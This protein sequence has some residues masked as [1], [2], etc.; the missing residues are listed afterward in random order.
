MKEKIL[1]ASITSERDK[2]FQICTKIIDR[3]GK[4]F[5]RKEALNNESKKHIQSLIT[6]ENVLKET[7]KNCELFKIRKISAINDNW[8]EFSF[9]DGITLD[10]YLN[11]FNEEK[12]TELL[13]GLWNELLNCPLTN[14]KVNKSFRRVF[15][16]SLTDIDNLHWSKNQNVDLLLSNI[17]LQNDKYIIS[18]YEW[19][20]SFAVPLEFIYFRSVYY[21][22]AL[23]DK[24]RYYQL[25]R[26]RKSD[27]N[28][29][30]SAEKAFQ[31]F[32]AGNTVS[33]WDSFDRFSV[34]FEN[35][36]IKK[37]RSQEKQERDENLS[38]NNELRNKNEQIIQ[39]LSSERELIEIK[40]SA[41][42]K[43]MYGW[44]RLRDKILPKGSRRRIVVKVFADIIRHPVKTISKLSLQRIGKFIIFLIKG[45]VNKIAEKFDDITIS[46][47]E[48]MKLDVSTG[49]NYKKLYFNEIKDPLISVIVPVYNQF[50]Y[51]YHCLEAIL[52]HCKNVSYEVILADDNSNDQTEKINEY[53][54]NVR[55]IRNK[56]NLGFLRNCNSASKYASGKYIVFLN[57]DTQVQER[58][59]ESMLELIESDVT[60]GMVGSRLVY[61]DGSLQEAGGIIWADGSGWNYGRG[62]SPLDP[63]YNYV[64]DVDYISGAS[65]MIRKDLWKKIGGFD[66]RYA[67][68]YYEDSDLTFNVRKHGYRVVYQPQSVVVHFEGVTNGTDENSGH[69][70]YQ[71]VNKEKFVEKWKNELKDQYPSESFL[72]KARERGKNKKMD[73]FIDHY[74]P[75]YDKDAGSKSSISYMKLFLN[76]GYTVKLIPDNFYKDEPY[77][78]QFQQM[79]IEVLY[80]DWYANHI[81]DWLQENSKD[82]DYIFSNRPHITI[83]YIDF[84]KDR[85]DIKLVYYGHDLH[86]LRTGREYEVNKDP[87]IFKEMKDWEEKEMHIL[88]KADMSY[89]P[90][91]T[92]VRTLKKLDE[93]IRVK[94]IPLYIYDEFREDVNADFKKRKGLLFVGGFRHRPNLDAVKWLLEE[95][96]PNLSNGVEPLY[97]VGSNPPDE[98]L[99]Y[100]IEK[101]IIKGFVSEEELKELYDSCRIVIAPLR[102][103]AG[104]K[105]KI[106][107]AMYNGVPTVTTSIGAE[108]IIDSDEVLFIED[109]AQG[110]AETI[111]KTYNDV[112]LL[113][114]RSVKSLE[115]VKHH[116]SADNAW[117]II[118]E[119]FS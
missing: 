108:G 33:L 45:D 53:A 40:Q 72:F 25:A 7:Y 66:E 102:Y 116:F 118:E 32:V 31:D 44:Y 55:I 107:E 29:F 1:F 38:L 74:V 92:E 84:I 76:K 97:I 6:N 61:P 98:L 36:E 115:Y 34:G 14:I 64:K 39:L 21:S 109:D 62:R 83:K 114:E 23:T 95:I 86:F 49:N 117:N 57:N 26:I 42:V 100:Q 119:D 4:R 13:T 113:K 43:A 78:T 80:G 2:R 52:K 79:G 28:K 88:K 60:I 50:D 77:T 106:I 48:R 103:G 99:K 22:D 24:D 70:Q 110:I 67:P 20:F 90:S 9:L 85:T 11:S 75:Q 91:V 82:I 71:K 12:K 47:F 56:E 93:T 51:T 63:E 15:G 46:D 10:T 89:Y 5:V 27:L 87:E 18:D 19:V 73:V 69:K 94:A 101:V 96:C 111:N 112:D 105:G 37:L 3:N 41:F 54:E 58:W 17:Y 8:I 65:I 68:A 59:L 35:W 16:G 81:F 104:I 30:V